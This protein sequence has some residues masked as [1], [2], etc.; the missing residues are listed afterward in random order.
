MSVYFVTVMDIFVLVISIVIYNAALRSYSLRV[1]VISFSGAILWG[2]ILALLVHAHFEHPKMH[3]TEEVLNTI[4]V[5]LNNPIM[6][7]LATIPNILCFFAVWMA[8]IASGALL[9]PSHDAEDDNQFLVRRMQWARMLLYISAVWLVTGTFA[10]GTM[11]YVPTIWLD[12][13]SATE[14]REI[15]RQMAALTGGLSSIFLLSVYIPTQ[16]M[17]YH[18]ALELACRKF[19]ADEAKSPQEWLEKRGLATNYWGT[20]PTVVAVLG[21]M[22]AGGPL[23]DVFRQIGG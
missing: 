10:V 16:M 9:A 12:E 14:L 7:L 19:T 18:Q 3:S 17:L 21:P 8:A 23:Q 20:I 15:S 1:R 5:G 22:L 11:Y 6:R 4:V 13:G 2:L